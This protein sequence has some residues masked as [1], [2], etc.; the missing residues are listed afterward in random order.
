VYLHIQY[1]VQILGV[2]PAE[3]GVITPYN[4]QLTALKDKIH[5]G[6][7]VSSTSSGSCNRSIKE[8]SPL[9]TFND[10]TTFI[11]YPSIEIRTVDG[12]Q[13]GEK[14]VI[15]LSLVRSNESRTVSISNL[16]SLIVFY[17][18]LLGGFSI[19]GSAY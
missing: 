11:T 13:G 6:S 9:V 19:R 14:E 3:I 10:K 4:G 1:L 8:Y 7:E 16:F 5:N 15:I 17:L 2:N 12:F 18:Q